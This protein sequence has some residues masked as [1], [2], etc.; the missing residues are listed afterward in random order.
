M[1]KSDKDFARQV[2][3]HIDAK[4]VNYTTKKGKE[5]STYVRRKL[6]FQVIEELRRNYN[7]PARELDKYLTW[8]NGAGWGKGNPPINT[9]PE[10]Y[11]RGQDIHYAISGLLAGKSRVRNNI[12]NPTTRRTDVMVNTNGTVVPA[13]PAATKNIEEIDNI[14]AA[15]LRCARECAGV[16][17]PHILA[18]LYNVSTDTID[19]IF[20]EISNVAH[21]AH[22]DEFHWTTV[23][24]RQPKINVGLSALLQQ[25]HAL[26]PEDMEALRELVGK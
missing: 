18:S 24:F 11:R 22:N 5:P 13:Y 25:L 14:K 20:A 1:I 16:P 17:S 2:A 21:I 15:I 26:S 10:E 7:K 6:K 23:E 4:V 3:D 19:D 12:D 9:T 8:L